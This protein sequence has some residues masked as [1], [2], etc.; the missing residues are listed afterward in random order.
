MF[1]DYMEK[2]EKCNPS[3]ITNDIRF[4]RKSGFADFDEKGHH[5]N[6]AGM[7]KKVSRQIV[8]V[9][10]PEILGKAKMRLT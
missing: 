9:L 4:Y 8:F 10:I 7:I 5:S 1:W 2:E 3:G 6:I